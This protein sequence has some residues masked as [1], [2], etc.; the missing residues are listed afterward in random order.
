MFR[1][2]LVANRGEIAVRVIRALKE[3]GIPAVAVYSEVDRT[4]LHVR[5]AGEAALLGPA[6]AAESYLRIDRILDAAR[7]HRA[8]AVHPGY[9]F[10]SENA[11]FA[12]ACR[13]A[14]LVFIGPSA[15]SIRV[16]GSKTEA[17]RLARAAG[18][19]VV[20]G[21]EHGVADVAEARRVADACGYPVMLKAAAGGG[22]KGMRRVDAPEQLE[23]ALRD[24]SSE[25]E[26]AFGDGSVYIEKLIVRPRHIEVQVFGDHHGN[27]IHLGERECSLQR[28]HQKVV[29]ECPS[30]LVAAYPDLRR[31]LGEAAIRAAR[32][33]GYFNAGTVE[34]LVDE[35][36]NFYFL[37]M[38]TRL[39]VEHPVTELVTGLDLVHWQL[40]VAAGEPLP[41]GQEDITWRGAALECRI[42]A[43]DPDN[44]FFPSPGLIQYLSRPAGPG[45][46]L[47]SGVYEGFTVPV[48]YD[49][50]LAKLAVWA[51]DRPRAIA[52][53]IRALEEYSIAGIKTN[54][55]FFRQ[56]LEDPEFRAGRLHTG[57]IDEFFL[58][59]PDQEDGAAPEWEAIAALI[60]ALHRSRNG[61]ARAPA[62][63]APSR[64]RSEGR[65]R[66]LR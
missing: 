37:E 18:V 24:A 21:T 63:P 42:Y 34:F 61:G 8:D 2:V 7:R 23:A 4:A 47:D 40:R 66:L 51:A 59:R 31:R 57:L 50:L 36:R 26:R 53:M 56:I 6:P 19:P 20:P 33:A 15:E 38:N 13:D 49:P 27:L 48:E 25:A 46:R 17:R 28:R 5:M 44:G 64:W 62:P 30:P 43:E 3:L 41:L 52:R 65:E 22:G 45:V 16:M 39:Q 11:A 9:G 55:G 14:G 32:A 29:E 1:K 60:G 54:T 10:L 58:R 12:A 35:D